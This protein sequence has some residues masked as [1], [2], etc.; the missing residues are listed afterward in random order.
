[1]PKKNDN[2]VGSSEGPIAGDGHQTP[3]QAALVKQGGGGLTDA[4]RNRTWRDTADGDAGRSP[5]AMGGSSQG[6]A[7]RMPTGGAART[8][9]RADN[10]AVTPGHK[11][12]TS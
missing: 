5:V 8:N 1:M 2:V 3:E 4:E 6:Q 12:S 11:H 10:P 9:Q 7:D